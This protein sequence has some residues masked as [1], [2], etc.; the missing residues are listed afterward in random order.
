MGVVGVSGR[1]GRSVIIDDIVG[2][3]LEGVSGLE[4]R[5]GVSG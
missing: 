1:S 3:G 4:E 5:A 2:A